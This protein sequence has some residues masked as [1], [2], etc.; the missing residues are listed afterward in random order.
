MKSLM[1]SFSRQLGHLCVLCE[2]VD[3]HTHIV[4]IAIN[5]ATD[6]VAD[7]RSLAVD[8]VSSRT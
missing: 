6:R 5:L 4:P 3:I 8:V 7:V 1:L 2:P